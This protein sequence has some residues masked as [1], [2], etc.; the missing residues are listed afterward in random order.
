VDSD[1]LNGMVN[2]GTT[3]CLGLCSEANIIIANTWENGRDNGTVSTSEWKKDVIIN[4]AILTLGESFTFQDQ[5][6]ALGGNLPWWY[7]SNGPTPDERGQIHLWGSLAQYRRGYVHRSNH[8]GTGYLKDYHY[9]NGLAQNPPPYFPYLPVDMTFS[10]EVLDFSE[11]EVGDTASQS[12]WAYNFCM[13]S[14]NIESWGFSDPSFSGVLSG[15]SLLCA[16]DST[17]MNVYFHPQ[18]AVEFEE[19]LTFFT[20]QGDYS[21]ELIGE[22]TGTKINDEPTSVLLRDFNL[23]VARPNPF[24]H[25]VT[26]E[27]SVKSPKIV[28]ISISDIDGREIYLNS[29]SCVSGINRIYWEPDDIA[30]GLYLFHLQ[31]N[32]SSAY[33]KLLYL[34]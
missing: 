14:I 17:M 13:D 1:L 20:D 24:N 33:G 7:Y 27:F 32:N 8:Y 2:L 5:N 11:V 4:G 10:D 30:S 31:S 18:S 25:E 22:G 12:L 34:K 6:D 16:N 15:D 26:I 28:W 21:I 29:Y 19:Q 3:N 9:Y 23:L